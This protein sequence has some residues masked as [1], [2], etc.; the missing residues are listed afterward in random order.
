MASTKERLILEGL[1]LLKEAGI[2]NLNLRALAA[3]LG[4]KAPSIYEHFASKADLLKTL[5][6]EL[7]QRL[8]RQMVEAMG[9]ETKAENR[10]LALGLAFGRFFEDEPGLSRLL[11]EEL[12]LRAEPSTAPQTP[13]SLLISEINRWLT[14][15]GGDRRSSERI[16]Y[17]FWSILQGGLVMRQSLLKDLR[18]PFSAMDKANLRAFMAGIATQVKEG[19]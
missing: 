12:P 1:N 2:E 18:A 6:D 8:A 19:A 14:S 16:A 10:L 11:L 3:R 9:P 13:Y 7:W 4:I 17:G 15:I 5:R